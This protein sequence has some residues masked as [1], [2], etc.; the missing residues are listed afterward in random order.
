MDR[1]MGQ[2]ECRVAVASVPG[3]ASVDREKTAEPGEAGQ[4]RKSTASFAPDIMRSSISTNITMAC[5]L[6]PRPWLARAAEA[7]ARRSLSSVWSSLPRERRVAWVVAQSRASSSMVSR[8]YSLLAA[9]VNFF[10]CV[11]HC[12]LA[13]IVP[14]PRQPARRATQRGRMTVTMRR[15]RLFCLQ[16]E[17]H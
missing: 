6:C 12:L 9:N 4:D 5:W 15:Q 14:Q 3:P 13:P 8:I 1:R 16:S 17:R 2:G 11:P 7:A 10:S